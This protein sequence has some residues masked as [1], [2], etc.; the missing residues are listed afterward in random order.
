MSVRVKKELFDINASLYVLSVLM[1]KPLLLQDDK[2]A[3]VKTD[4]YHPLHE[5]VFYAIFNLA[6]NG[7]E[8]ITPQDIDMQI[9]QFDAKY[10]YFKKHDGYAW[11]LQCYQ[12]TENTDDKQFDLYYQ[13]V[14]KFSVLR[15]LE[16][17]GI[18]TTQFYDPN[19]D[20]LN[21]DLEDERLNKESIEEILNTVRNDIVQIENT[22]I[23]K[24]NGNAQLAATGMRA[25]VQELEAHP[26]VGLPL[27]GKIVNWAARGARQGKM[28]IYSAP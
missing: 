13:R 12:M 14:K 10:E 15:D 4:F 20:A 26:E 2:Y 9:K 21:R 25:L 17:T 5:M 8:K 1:H 6:Q 7:V 28:Y 16:A 18:D 23:G 11:T 19:K 3:F 24:D 27:D 22:H